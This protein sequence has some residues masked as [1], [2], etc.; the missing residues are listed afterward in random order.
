MYGLAY[1]GFSTVIY[2]LVGL[3]ALVFGAV[4]K[5]LSRDKA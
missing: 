1:T 5:F 2:A 3:V 4:V